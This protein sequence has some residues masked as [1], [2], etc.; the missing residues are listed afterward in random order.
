MSESRCHIAVMFTDIVGYTAIMGSDEDKAFE[1]LKKNREIHRQQLA[2]FNGTLIKE[3]GDGMLISFSLASDAV[4][5]AIE[6]QKAC[7]TQKIPLKIGIHEGEMVFAGADVLGDAVNVASRLES[8]TKEGCIY[9]S[10]SVF[11]D[12]KNRTD[13]K[14][15]FVKE[16]T[17]KNVDDPIKVYQ[18]LCENEATKQP[19]SN[20]N[21][22]GSTK[23]PYFMLVGLVVVVLTILIVWHII[24][25][26]PTVELEKSIAVLPF[27]YLSEAQNKRYLADG[28]VD[29][30]TGHLSTIK[31]LRVM[32]RTS[33]EQYRETTKP[34]QVI[35]KELNV[36]YLVEGSF[37]MVGDQVK[38]I[39]Q[40]IVASKNDHLYFNEFDRDYKDILTV[41]SELART[42]AE[43]IGIVLSPDIQERMES[44]PTNNQQAYELYLRGKDYF[45][46]G[47]ESNLNTA[48]HF[49]QQS[50]ESDTQFAL[51]YVWLGLAL[52]NQS[53]WSDYFKESFGDTLNYYANKAVALNPKL[54]EGYWLKGKHMQLIGEKDMSLLDFKKAIELNPNYADAYSSLSQIYFENSQFVNAITNLEKAKKL[55]KG[56]ADYSS[57]LEFEGHFY[58]NIGDYENA[59][60]AFEQLAFFEPLEGY[61]WL[62][63]LSETYGRWD[64]LKFYA[65]KICSI[66]SGVLCNLR[67]G[68]WNS[69]KKNFGKGLEYL[70]KISESGKIGALEILHR[71]R[72]GY[73][74]F[75]LGRIEEANDNFNKQIEYC[76]ESI[77]L[78]RPYSGA[79]YD[80]A[81]VYAFIGEKQ[82]ALEIL[83]GIEEHNIFPASLMKYAQFDPLYE[84][85]WDDQG[86]KDIITKQ[87]AR[88]AKIRSELDELRQQGD[89]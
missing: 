50:I 33:V 29:A 37:Q 52:N 45:Y 13:I 14:T 79:N 41:Q 83:N 22:N 85:L 82:K 46:K 23:K 28:V 30:I 53:Y 86:F 84:S 6:I 76:R 7:K 66:D 11:R 16:K 15:K 69:Y 72:I 59:K 73:V 25:S 8:D 70:S 65:D 1:V 3:M 68:M 63:Y 67:L 24:P 88:F 48:I 56:T 87:E 12:I 18:V 26:K 81:G 20:N 43:E 19:V 71:H 80:L 17:F 60:N 5:C 75:N 89:I 40:L 61:R 10:G 54:A 31:G 35:G 47:G 42:I 34:S 77:R 27:E 2:K 49:F 44:I 62:G 55:K 74:L 39:I 57:L 58:H 9:I 36:S 38:L 51:A 32:P 21:E 64:D 78:N 4:R